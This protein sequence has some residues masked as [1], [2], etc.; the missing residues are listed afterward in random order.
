M[1][2][3]DLFPVVFPH[4]ITDTEVVAAIEICPLEGTAVPNVQFVSAAGR[5]VVVVFV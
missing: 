2:A 1:V 3:E 5:V 4:A